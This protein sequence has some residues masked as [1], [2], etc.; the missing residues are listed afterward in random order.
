MLDINVRTLYLSEFPWDLLALKEHMRWLLAREALSL[1]A[2]PPQPC[3]RSLC[4]CRAVETGQGASCLLSLFR[5]QSHFSCFPILRRGATCCYSLDFPI[6]NHDCTIF[7]SQGQTIHGR[8][9]LALNQEHILVHLNQWYFNLPC[10]TIIW[11]AFKN[12]NCWASAT[13]FLIT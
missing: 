9:C 7:R 5:V 11:K 10:T 8:L 6:G 4:D 1:M 2:F 13:E 3:P 12:T